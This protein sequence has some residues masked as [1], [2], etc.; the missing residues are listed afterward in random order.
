MTIPAWSSTDICVPQLCNELNI[1]T[2]AMILHLHT[3]WFCNPSDIDIVIQTEY[4]PLSY[5]SHQ[6]PSVGGRSCGAHYNNIMILVMPSEIVFQ[7]VVR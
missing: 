1:L 5:R 3:L 2:I 4:L 7:N 6:I